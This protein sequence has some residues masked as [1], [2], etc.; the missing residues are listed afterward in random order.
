MSIELDINNLE[1]EAEEA[2]ELGDKYEKGI[3][4]DQSFE[5]AVLCYKYAA[6]KD[7]SLAQLLYGKLL[8]EGDKVEKDEESGAKF[9][10][11]SA[12]SGNSEAQWRYA[13]LL[14]NGIGVEVDKDAAYHYY[15]LSAKEN[16]PE[17]LWRFGNAI[18]F[19][20]N[21]APNRKEAS[22]YYAQSAEAGN[23][24]GKW[25]Y[26]EILEKGDSKDLIKAF[27]L[28]KECADGDHQTGKVLYARA[29]LFGLGT[30]K[31]QAEGFNILKNV[32]KTGNIL[33][34]LLVGICYLIGAGTEQSNDKSTKIFKA[35]AEKQNTEGMWRYARAL[36][37]GRGVKQ[38]LKEAEVFYKK[39]ADLGDSEAL[40]RL[41]HFSKTNN[42]SENYD[43]LLKQS[44]EKGNAI[45]QVIYSHELLSK[46]ASEETINEVSPLLISSSEQGNT[47][48]KWILGSILAH[49]NPDLS[50]ENIKAASELH[51]H[52]ADWRYGLLLHK[53]IGAPQDD[54]TA[55]NII[56][57][58]AES[59]NIEALLQYGYFMETAKKNPGVAFF[60]YSAAANKGDKRG[61]YFQGISL[62]TGN[63]CTQNREEGAKLVQQA[64]DLGL[65][66]AQLRTGKLYQYGIGF[67]ENIDLAKK[68]YALASEQGSNEGKEILQSL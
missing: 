52:E 47:T 5:N 34:S 19:G 41:A 49:Q 12:E 40:W 4:V 58:A 31:N 63:G 51:S 32:S 1:C 30:E 48:A 9:L 44:V 17:G 3:E 22:T 57:Q 29:L 11:A 45:A 28:Y 27:N 18:E 68:Y 64:A 35:A 13:L 6:E 60:A 43:Q 14:Q 21:Q 26:G 62:I 42:K 67:D 20:L 16:N 33:A 65:I 37:L 54:S 66:E 23:L 61:K 53:G 56:R 2:R 24:E 38:N 7:D 25:R 8:I 59:G 10:L 50:I 55:E 36:E 46:S 15:E 39:A